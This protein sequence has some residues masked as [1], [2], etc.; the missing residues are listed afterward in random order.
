MAMGAWWGNGG[1]GWGCGWGNNGGSIN[2]NNNN[3]F[4]RNGNIRNG[5]NNI[6]G[7]NRWQ[8][9]PE[10][11]GGAPYRDRATAD[12]FGGGARG[13]SIAN[14]QSN[15]RN[16]IGRQG[17]NVASQRLAG[18]GDGRPSGAPGAGAGNGPRGGAGG[19]PP[20]RGGRGG[21]G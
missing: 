11:R 12:R 6:G 10:H 5:G 15:A 17:G 2:I 1:G 21:G 14:R 3:A 9:R 20:A 13:D 7:G 4:V 19:G 18:G 16:E 8:H